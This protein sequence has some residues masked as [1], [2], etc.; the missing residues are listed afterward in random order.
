MIAHLL[1]R[2]ADMAE[3]IGFVLDQVA[4]LLVPREEVDGA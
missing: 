1:R 4:D 3:L 2:A